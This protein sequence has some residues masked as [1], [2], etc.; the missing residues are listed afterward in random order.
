[1]DER[2][3]SVCA[4]IFPS[5]TPNLTP[6]RAGHIAVGLA[7]PHYMIHRVYPADPSPPIDAFGPSQLDYE[8]VK[9]GLANWP[10]RSWLLYGAL[11]V[12]VAVHMSEGM[13]IIMRRTVKG[14]KTLSKRGRRILASLIAA[15]VLSGLWVVSREPI[16]T[17]TSNA[18][19]FQAAFEK[20]AFYRL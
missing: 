15:P 3:D 18:L 16:M 1:M 13:Q 10:I 9:T 19:R 14:A 6:S 2:H 17:F 8:F 20:H 12:A 5:I 4:P 7:L 11:T